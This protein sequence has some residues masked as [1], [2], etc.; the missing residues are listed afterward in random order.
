MTEEEVWLVQAEHD[1]EVAEYNLRGKFYA[2]CLVNCQQATEKALK[3]IYIA[4]HRQAPPRIHDIRALGGLVGR[5]D[6]APV[7]IGLTRWYTEARYPDTADTPAY[8]RATAED[9]RPAVEATARFLGQ[10]R[11]QL[12]A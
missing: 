8:E 4:K 9:A 2:Q 12:C 3:A 7:L 6:L 10:T 1:L 5:D 11:D